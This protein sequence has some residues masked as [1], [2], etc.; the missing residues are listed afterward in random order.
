MCQRA[1]ARGRRRIGL[2]KDAIEAQTEVAAE[3]KRPDRQ[4]LALEFLDPIFKRR[5]LR[6][7]RPG[8]RRRRDFFLIRQLLFTDGFL[9]L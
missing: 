7:R 2:A 6:F 8:T 1:E 3:A 9:R 4:N 5:S